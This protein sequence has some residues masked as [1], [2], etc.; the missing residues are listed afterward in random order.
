MPGS[1]STTSRAEAHSSPWVASGTSSGVTF[2]ARG[3]ATPGTVTV[4][5]QDSTRVYTLTVA[6]T[7]EV[8]SFLRSRG[9]TVDVTQDA[10]CQE[11]MEQF[12]RAH[13][14][15]WAEDIGTEG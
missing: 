14:T 12:I 4:T 3:T 7:D 11:L 8:S 15:L 10:R 9:V 13:P 5:R 2:Y 1:P 6:A